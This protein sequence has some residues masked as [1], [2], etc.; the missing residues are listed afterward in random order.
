MPIVNPNLL[1]LKSAEALA[2]LW[3]RGE[4]R[5]S[6]RNYYEKMTAHDAA[7]FEDVKQRYASPSPATAASD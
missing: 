6:R 2:D 7:E 3:Q 4:F 1:A 5:V